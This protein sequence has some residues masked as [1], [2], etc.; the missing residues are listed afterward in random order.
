MS[1][2]VPILVLGGIGAVLGIGLA[3]A[4]RVFAV[5]EDPRVE[6]LLEVL[7]GAN[8][9]ACG[10][11][12]C[13]GYAKGLSAG[14]ADLTLC[15]PGGN[16]TV[17][18]VA[19]ILGVEAVAMVEKVA[20][21]RCAGTTAM[22]PDRSTYVG[23]MDCRTAALVAAGNKEC[24]WGCLGLGSCATV[25]ED[26]AIDFVD[27]IA[28]VHPDRCI[29]CKRCLKECPRDLIEMVP[30]DRKVHVLC[31][32]KDPGKVTKSA[33]KVGCIACKLCTKR[34][35]VTFQMDGDVAR[36]DYDNGKDV[37]E[38]AMVC[39]PGSI[40]NQDSCDLVTW[41]TDPEARTSFK[42]EQK[43][44]KEA[45]KAAKKAAKE[46]TAK[47]TADKETS[48]KKAEKKADEPEAATNDSS[49]GKAE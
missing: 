48:E 41:L 23:P 16:A 13:S 18:L 3:V 42:K 30:K 37:P 19:N 33:C 36:I 6:Q 26:D 5:E 12:G 35:K 2:L 17:K 27:G 47:K 34:D 14:Q 28:F 32:S 44:F 15:A 7:P 22:A 10:Y 31:S 24:R 25:C 29:G 49:K 4:S 9:G 45:E 39:T 43:A 38:A 11:P 20:L 1:M 21:V 8:C 46:A 40:W